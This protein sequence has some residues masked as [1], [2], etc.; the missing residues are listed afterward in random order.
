MRNLFIAF[1]L[2]I[3]SACTYS[4]TMTHS[5]GGPTDID[6]NQKADADIKAEVPTPI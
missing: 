4:I 2:V 1:L 3:L 6:E 5:S